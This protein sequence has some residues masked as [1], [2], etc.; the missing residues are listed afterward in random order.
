MKTKLIKA[1]HEF[2]GVRS[3]EG[4]LFWIANL[5][6]KLQVWMQDRYPKIFPDRQYVYDDED[7]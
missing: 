2:L 7:E 5:S 6:L 1:I 3:V 4:P